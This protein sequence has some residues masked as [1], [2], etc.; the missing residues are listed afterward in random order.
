VRSRTYELTFSGQAG[1]ATCAEFDD[2]YVAISP[3]TTTLRCEVPDQAALA[4]LIQRIIGLRL[5]ITQVLLVEPAAAPLLIPAPLT[6]PP[7]PRTD[8]EPRLGRGHSDSTA[9]QIT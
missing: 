8:R 9:T 4:G 1:A 6:Y 7:Y 3:E 5:E 2:C